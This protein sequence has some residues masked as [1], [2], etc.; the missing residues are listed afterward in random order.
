MPSSQ[1]LHGSPG[2]GLDCKV[3]GSGQLHPHAPPQGALSLAEG[4]PPQEAPFLAEGG[5]P[6]EAPFRAGSRLVPDLSQA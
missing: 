6:P 5:H 4:V 3:G 2:S 1:V